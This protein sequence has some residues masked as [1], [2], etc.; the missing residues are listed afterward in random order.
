MNMIMM[1][2]TLVTMVNGQP[3]VQ[4]VQ[5][6]V[7]FESTCQILKNTLTLPDPTARLE[8]VCGATVP[9]DLISTPRMRTE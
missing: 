9:I 3:K 2:I 6:H 8:I 4:W 7:V 5:E 1:V